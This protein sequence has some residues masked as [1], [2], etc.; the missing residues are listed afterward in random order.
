MRFNLITGGCAALLASFFLSG[1]ATDVN[2]VVR[3]SETNQ[4]IAGAVVQI[5]EESTATDSEGFYSLKADGDDDDPQKFHV[6][7]P[8]YMAVSDVRILDSENEPA[9]IDF[10]LRATQAE[11]T[12][13][14]ESE[15]AKE[16]ER[17]D[18]KV[19]SST[20]STTVDKDGEVKIEDKATAKPGQSEAR[21]K[22][23]TDDG[24]TVETEVKG[25]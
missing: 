4:P 14:G 12:R 6:A 23:T 7:A 8:G 16:Q 1:C 18:V 5:G 9:K 13:N 11:R 10:N 19:D 3:D 24:N 21:T 2:G 20:S 17:V 22:V 15:R 25:E